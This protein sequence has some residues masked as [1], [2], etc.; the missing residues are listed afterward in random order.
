MRRP[1]LCATVLGAMTAGCYPALDWRDVRPEGA[2]LTALFP[3]RPK[4]QTR[5]VPLA[6]GAVRMTLW[7]CSADG[8]TF[9]LGHAEVG[10]PARVP[11]ALLQLGQSL[12]ANVGAGEVRSA[13]L[14]LPAMT[15]MPQ[16]RRFW[17]EGRLPDSTP[18][19]EQAAVFARGSRVYQVAVLGPA[20]DAAAT[21][22]FDG[23]RLAP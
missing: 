8:M 5:S 20:V 3:C 15:P 14:Q 18:V 7:S 21:V 6:G 19:Q 10:D 4:S 23:L 17:L 11:D 16:A 1:A 9:A 22:F 13:P 12:A 2:G